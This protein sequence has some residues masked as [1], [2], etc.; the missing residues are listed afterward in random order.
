[1]DISAIEKPS[2]AGGVEF[3]DVQDHLEGSKM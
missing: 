1:M 3:E 2:V